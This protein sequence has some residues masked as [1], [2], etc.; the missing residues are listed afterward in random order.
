MG[1]RRRTGNCSLCRPAPRPSRPAKPRTSWNAIT[2][3]NAAPCW[4]AGKS[5]GKIRHGPVRI[6]QDVHHLQTFQQGEV[7]VTDKT[8]PDWEPIMQRAAAIIT[9]RR[10]A[11][12]CRHYRRELGVP[13]VVGTEHGTGVLR[14][15]QLVTVSC[16]EGETGLVYDGALPFTVERAPCGASWRSVMTNWYPWTS[17]GMPIRPLWMRRPPWCWGAPWLRCWPGT[18]TSGAMPVGWPSWRGG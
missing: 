3:S 6:I 2:Y 13:A 10:A 5:V 8:D 11:P 1:Q 16:A 9:N 18:T 4:S 15:G 12:P 14:D 17:L 7:L